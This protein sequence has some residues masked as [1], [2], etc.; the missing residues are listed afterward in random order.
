M[1]D[2]AGRLTG[3]DDPE[4]TGVAR[5]AGAKVLPLV[6]NSARYDAFHTAIS[7]PATRRNMV[8]AISGMVVA[9]RYDGVNIDFEAVNADDRPY[10]TSF[11]AELYADMHPKGKLVTIAVAAKTRDVTTG[12]GGSYDYKALAPN[13]DYVVTMAY[14]FHYPGGDAGAVAPVDWMRDH[15]RFALSE[16]GPAKLIVG[17]PLYGYDWNVTTGANATAVKYRQIAELRTAYG[18]QV[19]YDKA[20]ESG[21]AKYQKNGQDHEVW[22]D[23]GR[24]FDAKLAAAR[25]LGAAGVAVWRL[26]QEDPRIWNSLRGVSVGV[27]LDSFSP[28]ADGYNDVVSA[29]YRI[30]NPATVRAYV[31]N[32]EGKLVR[33]LLPPT[34]Q[35]AGVGT[36]K[37]DGL[38]N[39]SAVAPDGRYTIRVAS[40]IVNSPVTDEAYVNLDTSVTGMTLS[41]RLYS[42]NEPP[43][44]ASFTL[45]SPGRTVVQVVQGARVVKTLSPSGYHGVGEY[46]YTWNGRTT[47]S[48]LAP[49]AATRC[50]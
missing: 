8:S 1:V 20:S 10:L 21:W 33:T 49:R 25:S 5:A 43:L 44:S 45:T 23:N 22:F 26:G 31:I 42:P 40:T 12:W 39:A 19:G 27:S 32:A 41:T 24:S 7:D 36:V 6:Q 30:E 9:N 37:W 29:S 46:S 17:M 48:L 2:A 16:F 34:A 4:A 18:A 35:S 38:T 13:I 3:A 28:N 15:V 50:E 14:D 11:M 47:D